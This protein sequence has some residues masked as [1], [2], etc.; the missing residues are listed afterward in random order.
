[1]IVGI[2]GS[3]HG[4]SDAQLMKLRVALLELGATELRHGDCVGVDA[5]S[6]AIG[7]ELRLRIVVH[8]PL[9]DAARA[10]CA[11]DVILPPAG[12]IPRDHDL[13]D[14]SAYLVAL[15]DGP[16][17][18]RSGTWATVRYARRRLGTDRIRI[19]LP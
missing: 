7:R 5:Q 12:Y 15:P 4:A 10:W 1:M 3:R 11:G 16:E 2:T 14:A 13:V 8:P 6:H 9:I 18:V 17:R 19:I